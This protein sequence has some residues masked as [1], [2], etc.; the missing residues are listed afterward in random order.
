MRK[1]ENSEEYQKNK[2]NELV[3]VKERG[4]FERLIWTLF[5]SKGTKELLC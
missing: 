1:I 3:Y 2:K 4:L 5:G